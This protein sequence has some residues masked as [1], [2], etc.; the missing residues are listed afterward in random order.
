MGWQISD[1]RD[2][3]HLVVMHKIHSEYV[4][5][6]SDQR[7]RRLNMNMKEVVHKEIVKL[8]D[9]GVINPIPIVDGLCNPPTTF[10]R[11]MTS[12]FTDMIE[13]IMEVFMDDISVFG[14]TNLV[15]NWEKFHFMV[16]EGIVLSYNISKA[17]IEV[18][19]AK[20]EVIEKLPPPTTIKGIHAFLG[21]CRFY[22]RFIKDI[23]Y[24][25]KPLTNLLIKDSSFEF[26][27]ECMLV[28]YYASRTMAGPQLNY[29]I[30]EKKILAV[31]FTLDKFWQYL[32]G[33]KIRDKKGMKNVVADH[34]SRLEI[35]EP[36]PIGFEVN[37]RFTYEMLMMIS[38]VE[39][40]WDDM[41]RRYVALIQILPILSH[42]HGSD[43][44]GHYGA[45]RTAAKALESGF[46]WTTL[47]RD[48]KDFVGHFDR[49]QRVANI[50]KRDEMPLTIIQEVK[51][52]DVWGIDFIGPFPVSFRNQYIL[53]GVD[54]VSKWVEAEALPTN[55]TKVVLRLLKCL[56]NRFGTP[57]GDY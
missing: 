14:E 18:D 56:M 39:T 13:D 40:P 4:Y 5:K 8:L 26:T 52:F 1:I 50:S 21:H 53:L 32:L 15:L 41:L 46:F 30:T 16:E 47:F 44:A 54:Y 17:G 42:C 48:A 2:I 34:L 37:E 35:P 24:I 55:D 22:R 19:I 36:I 20:T 28:I 6:A 3:S 33:S 23:S 57:K 11:C 45:F 9:V 10:Q 12:I 43:Y 31:V 7:Q 51:I 29:T 38:K 49:C 27:Y 25:A